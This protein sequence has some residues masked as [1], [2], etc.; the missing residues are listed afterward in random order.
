ML[1]L[2]T[3]IATSEKL[4]LIEFPLLHFDVKY[5]VR[6]GNR[7]TWKFRVC[8]LQNLIRTAFSTSKS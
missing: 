3:I 5:S 2:E 1:T 4:D 8:Q 6:S 7:K